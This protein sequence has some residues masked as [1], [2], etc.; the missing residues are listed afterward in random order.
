M[1]SLKLKNKITPIESRVEKYWKDF[2][3]FYESHSKSESSESL[4]QQLQSFLF[5]EETSIDPTDIQWKSL[6]DKHVKKCLD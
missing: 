3:D 4:N 2:Y 5:D 6:H 1:L